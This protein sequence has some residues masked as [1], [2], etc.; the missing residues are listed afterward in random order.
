MRKRVRNRKK[1]KKSGKLKAPNC[2]DQV[3]KEDGA[4]IR[5]Q[6]NVIEHPGEVGSEGK[7]ESKETVEKI[8]EKTVEILGKVVHQESLQ[9]NHSSLH[10]NHLPVNQFCLQINH[11]IVHLS[12]S[13]VS[14]EIRNSYTKRNSYMY[15]W[16]HWRNICCGK[17]IRVRL[18]VTAGKKPNEELRFSAESLQSPLWSTDLIICAPNFWNKV[19]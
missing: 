2:R 11:L 14:Y 1:N 8:K 18:G 3:L 12:S 10:F 16:I 5:K 13:R 17:F 4:M 19:V 9:F 7:I 15:K 6:A